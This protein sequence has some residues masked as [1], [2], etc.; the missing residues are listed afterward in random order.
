[1]SRTQIYGFGNCE[2]PL[3]Y[4]DP[5]PPPPPDDAEVVSGF[6]N[7]EAPLMYEERPEMMRKLL[8]GL[9]TVRFL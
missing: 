4:G 2:A 7:C 3:M 9:I 8:V 6:G 5:P 1:M